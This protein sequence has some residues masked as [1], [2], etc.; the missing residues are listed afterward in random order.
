VDQEQRIRNIAVGLIVCDGY[1]FAEEGPL[2]PGYHRFVRAIGGGIEFG[3][4][5]AEAVRREFREEL[6][7]DLA[8]VS[9]LAVTENL[10]EL[11][12]R[13]GHEI[14][15]VFTVRC[16]ELEAMPWDERRPILDNE[17]TAGWYPLEDVRAGEP[18]LYPDGMIRYVVS[19]SGSRPSNTAEVSPSVGNWHMRP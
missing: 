10:F 11:A 5:A 12:G 7:V 9:L 14:V 13:S 18:P 2:I 19:L 4:R 8:D 15:H 6:G 1:V 3:E 16:P 17:A